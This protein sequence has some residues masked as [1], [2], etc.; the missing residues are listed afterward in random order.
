MIEKSLGAGFGRIKR[1]ALSKFCRECEVF[2]ACRGG[3]PKHRFTT[4]YDN[5]FGLNYL[6][7]GYKKFFLHISKYL[8]VMTTLLEHGL[9]ASYVMDA[10][11]GPPLIRMDDKKTDRMQHPESRHDLIIRPSGKRLE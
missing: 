8:R 10:A 3:C 6:C 9:P 1:T 4:T 11:K 5:E 7:S 2:S